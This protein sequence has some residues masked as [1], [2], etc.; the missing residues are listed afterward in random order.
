VKSNVSIKT[1]RLCAL[2]CEARR[3]ERDIASVFQKHI[4]FSA[5]L[6]SVG[7]ADVVD[8]NTVN[9]AVLTAPG[10]EIAHVLHD[11]AALL[12]HQPSRICES[13]GQI[14]LNKPQETFH[15]KLQ[16]STPE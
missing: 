14:S 13:R 10:S 12:F 11:L 6:G 5:Y 7:L 3:N 4:P 16:P 8:G 9:P 2:V 15:T 1:A